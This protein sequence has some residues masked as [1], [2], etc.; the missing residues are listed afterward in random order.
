LTFASCYGRATLFNIDLLLVYQKYPDELWKAAELAVASLQVLFILLVIFSAICQFWFLLVSVSLNL[1]A[2]DC[3][4]HVCD[5]VPETFPCILFL[6][7]FLE[8]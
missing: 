7:Y 2:F 8:A 4:T 1:Y 5:V 3:Q 6:H